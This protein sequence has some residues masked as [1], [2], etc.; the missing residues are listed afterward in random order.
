MAHGLILMLKRVLIVDKETATVE[1]LRHTLELD[2]HTVHSEAAADWGVVEA[3]TFEPHLVITTLELAQDDEGWL[4]RQL[5]QEHERLPVLVVGSRPEYGENLPGFRLGVDEFLLRPAT[6]G[7]M[8]RRIEYLLAR[9]GSPAPDT[10]SHAGSAIVFGEIEVRPA[11]RTVVK[12]GTTVALRLKEFEL[13]M[14][15][16]S[17]EGAVASRTELLRCIWGYRTLVA[18]R[19]VDNHIGELRAKLED[20]PANPRYILTVR[21]VGYRLQR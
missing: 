1:G 11:A 13:L 12:R 2:G 17:R 18:T 3:R 21:K 10:M 5:R 15:L 19:T 6:V 16:V 20:N 7:E 9:N 8:H 4:L 14:A